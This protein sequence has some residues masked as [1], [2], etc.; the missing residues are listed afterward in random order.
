MSSNCSIGS[1]S[2]TNG[3]LC[4]EGSQ[5][6]ETNFIGT[7]LACSPENNLQKGYYCNGGLEIICPEKYYCPYKSAALPIIC[8]EDHYCRAGLSSP[9][10]CGVLNNCDGRGN[11]FKKRSWAAII[12]LFFILAILLLVIVFVRWQAQRRA[13][14]QRIASEKYDATAQTCET[15]VQAIK[16]DY[17]A[18]S[19]PLQGLTESVRYSKAVS[20]EFKDLSMTI[21]NT[22]TVVLN[23]VTGSFPPGSLVALMYIFF[24]NSSILSECAVH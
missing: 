7:C 6:L 20:I 4:E 3:A 17:A 2:C 13:K 22:D 24:K 11:S 12:L 1:T 5:S 18:G 15:I 14:R 10:D 9:L 21:K 19:I 16:G 23:G 8:P